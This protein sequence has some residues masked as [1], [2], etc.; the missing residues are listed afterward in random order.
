MKKNIHGLSTPVKKTVMERIAQKDDVSKAELL[1]EF[2]FTSSSLTRL[3]EELISEG[4]IIESGLGQSTGGRKPI[5]YR[6]N[7]T[8]RYI[9]GI[10]ISRIHSTIGL[11]DL[12]MNALE[13]RQW[14][15]DETMTPQILVNYVHKQMEEMEK[16]N[17]ISRDK[18]AGIGIGAVGPLDRETGVILNPLYFPAKGWTN[19][20]LCQLIEEKTGV[21]ALLDNGA[22]TALMGEH[23]AYRQEKIQHMLY[24]HVGTGLRS[25]MM[26]GGQLVYGAVDMEGSIGQMVIQID[27]PRLDGTGN[28]GALEAFASVQAM[29]RQAR[30][31]IKMG[32]MQLREAENLDPELV[33]FPLL[34]KALH[35]GDP[36]MKEMFLQ[37][38][39]YLGI[40][41]GNLINILHPEKV[42]LGGA[43]VNANDSYFDMAVATA[44]KNIYY[45]SEYQPVFT[46][47]I[48]QEH[49]V[50]VGAA[51]L[52]LK[53]ISI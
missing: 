2:S 41:L 23:W 26:S 15:M 8:H 53:Q 13:Y 9:F 52:V 5:L 44:Q 7:P 38:A 34:V 17:G 50:A 35:R 33:H 43:M 25:A 47:G 20:K 40:G 37:S 11:F 39:T 22:N 49:A 31:Q 48:F 42:I 30:F 12:K 36:Y 19:V 28:Y 45:A 14:P 3:L 46:R 29:E 32:R 27:G 16:R 4:W 1:A 18:I 51:V 21:T 6:I 24:I 10:E